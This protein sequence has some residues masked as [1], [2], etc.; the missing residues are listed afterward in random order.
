MLKL[1]SIDRTLFESKGQDNIGELK[2]RRNGK[3]ITREDLVTT[4]R[5]LAVEYAG[6]E[7]NAS[8]NAIEKYNSMLPEGVVL[9]Q[10]DKNYTENLFLYCASKANESVGRQA[11]A[12]YEEARAN[13]G[14]Y[15]GDTT[16]YKVLAA[17][18]EE[19]VRPVIFPVLESAT[20]NGMMAWDSVAFG[21]TK[22][23]K[24][25]SND[26]VVFE[27]TAEGA[28][29]NVGATYLYGR[30][31][32]ARPKLTAGKAVIRYYQDIVN[33]SAGSYFNAIIR[34]FWAKVYGKW[35]SVLA[36][37]AADSSYVPSGLHTST[38]TTAN[39]TAIT[40]A[41]GL[42]NGVDRK[43]VFAFGDILALQ[44]IVPTDG[45]G[46]AITGLQMGLGNEWFKNG[47]IGNVGGVDIIEVAPVVKPGTMNYNPEGIFPTNVIYFA[48][49]N[50]L[51]PP[52]AGVYYGDQNP[53]TVTMQPE[54]NADYSVVIDAQAWF[55]IIPLFASKIGYID[56]IS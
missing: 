50:G 31:V 10:L 52:F 5:L 1:N 6:N 53:M 20:M 36:A 15:A 37:A 9:S 23:Y 42:A 32:T 46:A 49:K 16:F 26:I 25:E 33:G 13:A 45:T 11:P 3:T 2:I 40:R 29:R 19:V 35:N 28:Q 17:I 22:E 4:G 8:R 41:V 56:S 30:T 55:D 39:F 12:T 34:G 48:A 18:T 54:F 24:V 14:A 43:A 21:G 44:K 38:Y 27:D 51:K 7:Y 47:F